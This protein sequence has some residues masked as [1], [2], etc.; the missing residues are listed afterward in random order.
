MRFDAD[1]QQII[2]QLATESCRALFEA[3]GVG[4]DPSDNLRN[5][6]SEVLLCGI[7][8]F[9]GDKVRGSLLLGLTDEP[10]QRSNPTETAPRDWVAEL[11]NQ[12]AGRLKNRLLAYGTEIYI[13]VPVV[14]RGEHIAPV[15]RRTLDPCA[16]T[17]GNGAV[18]VWAEVEVA[19]D[20]TLPTEPL[21][22]QGAEEGSSFLF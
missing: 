10:I 5:L 13:S 14:L 4:L 18:Y 9:T 6:P 21:E 7:I 16:L 12:L 1:S 19:D 3:Y 20:Y 15:P 11:A 2:N 8:G 22:E 17:P